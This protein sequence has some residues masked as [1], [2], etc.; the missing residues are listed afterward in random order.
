M[1]QQDKLLFCDNLKNFGLTI[2]DYMLAYSK[3]SSE[4]VTGDDLFNNESTNSVTE[5]TA[6]SARKKRSGS[7]TSLDTNNNPAK[8]SK[9]CSLDETFD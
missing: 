8:D 9:L 4:E 5:I 1:N 2:D 3:N 6:S 7:T